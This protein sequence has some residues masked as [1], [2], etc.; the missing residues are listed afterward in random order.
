LFKPFPNYGRTDVAD[1]HNGDV[2]LGHDDL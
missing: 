1:T 2:C